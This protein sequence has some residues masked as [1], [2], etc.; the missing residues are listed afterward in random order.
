MA[1]R[2]RHVHPT[3]MVAHLWAHQTQGSARNPHGNFYFEG[4]TIYSYGSHFPIARH[5]DK[6]TILFTTCGY[7]PTTSGHIS[8]VRSA[9]PEGKTVFHVCNPR[10]GA[11]GKD[12][13]AHC[14]N[15]DD[16]M[17]GIEDIKRSFEGSRLKKAWYLRQW[18]HAIEHANAYAKYFKLGRRPIKLKITA[19]MRKLIKISEEKRK[20]HEA[21][22]EARRVARAERFEREHAEQARLKREAE[23]Q[24]QRERE[25]VWQA[26]LRG[27]GAVSMLKDRREC[28]VMLRIAPSERCTIHKPGS[29][30]ELEK[31]VET[32][33]GAIVPLEDVRKA[34]IIWSLC[35]RKKQ[36]WHRNGEQIKV[37]DFQLDSISETGN[38]V[39]GCHRIHREEIERFAKTQSWTVAAAVNNRM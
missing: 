33:L 25:A 37:G 23:E 35:V 27:E 24:W 18:Q 14:E 26:W 10:A 11:Y 21:G 3:D 6:N 32:T 39:A 28:P 16:L 30:F 38:V 34:F 5:V 9:L 36:A 7:S 1:K 22:V 20:Q 4:N 29:S 12:R 17:A 2:T 8:C 31:F 19:A 13:V 15:H